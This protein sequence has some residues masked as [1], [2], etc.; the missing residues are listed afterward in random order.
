MDAETKSIPDASG[1]V[2]GPVPVAKNPDHP[3]SLARSVS[4]PFLLRALGA[5]AVV[6]AVGVFLFQ[7]WGSGDDLRRY[8]LLLGI[9]GALTFAGV[10]SATLLR[11]PKGA[12]TFVTLA[13]AS[14]PVG[15]TVAAALIYVHWHWD[16]PRS[17]AWEIGAW[18]IDSPGITAIA[19]AGGVALLALV[20]LLGFFVLARR[21]AW[22]LSLGYVLANGVLLVPVRESSSIGWLLVA[23]TVGVLVLV[24]DRAHRDPSLATL[25]GRI[26]GGLLFLPLIILGGRNLVFYA[27]DAMLA[28]T[29]AV[30]LHLL[31][32]TIDRSLPQSSVGHPAALGVNLATAAA[33]GLSAVVLANE[34]DFARQIPQHL[35]AG[36]VL[37]AVLLTETASRAGAKG[38]WI[39]Q[40]A[41]LVAVVGPVLDLVVS[42][43]QIDALVCILVGTT[44]VLGGFVFSQG[45]LALSGVVALILGLGAEALRLIHYFNLGGWGSLAAL[46][47]IAI[48]AGS[49]A[50]RYG[51][52]LK[53]G[54][55]GVGKRFR[56]QANRV[57]TH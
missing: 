1:E 47:I 10:A 27:P 41:A 42:G 3:W 17:L 9:I 44:L 55:L 51:T 43:S 39:Y 28:L 8:L 6:V 21:S 15:F 25:E 32:R 5:T 49:V 29:L 30:S 57:L 38:R 14:A 36:S 52:R 20:S 33:A 48:L 11:E 7:Q 45:L 40:V 18:R 4:L 2:E 35:S 54:L 34:I 46:G 19:V 16:L 26:A 12:R 53:G 23:T 37:F 24:T 22:A 13:L 31:V 56:E 50:E